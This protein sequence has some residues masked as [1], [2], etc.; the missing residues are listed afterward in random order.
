MVPTIYI[1]LLLIAIQFHC[2]INI[3]ISQ[4]AQLDVSIIVM[5]IEVTE[6][7]RKTCVNDCDVRLI[8]TT[9]YLM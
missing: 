4:N 5:L 6:L 8:F 3:T 9:H 2:D 1:I 7:W